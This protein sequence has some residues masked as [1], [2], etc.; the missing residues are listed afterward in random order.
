VC[1]VE[2]FVVWGVFCVFV[3]WEVCFFGLGGL[4]LGI[5]GWF[6]FVFLVGLLVDGGLVGFLVF[7]CDYGA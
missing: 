7:F 4:V 6:G 3:G 2:L 5:V 1:V